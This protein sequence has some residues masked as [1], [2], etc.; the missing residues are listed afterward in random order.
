MIVWLG[1]ATQAL[2]ASGA[3]QKHLL[4]FGRVSLQAAALCVGMLLH[5][6]LSLWFAALDLGDWTEK[7]SWV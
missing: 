3:G 5:V 1:V 4:Q 7:V 2:C 6:T